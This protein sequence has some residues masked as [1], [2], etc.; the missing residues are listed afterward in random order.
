MLPTLRCLALFAL[1][2]TLAGPVLQLQK[3]EGNRG[4][5]TVFLDSSESM[6]LKDKITVLEEKFFWQKNMVSFPE[7][8]N[9]VDYRFASASRK[10]ESLSES[11]SKIENVKS[12]E[13]SENHS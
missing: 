2:L 9:L 6:E 3:E 4:K 1:V 10:M 11:S 12:T 5:I 8:S 7:E 13:D